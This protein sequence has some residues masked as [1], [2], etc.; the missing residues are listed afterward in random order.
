MPKTRPYLFYDVALS[1]CSTCY[2]RKVEAKTV[3]QDGSVYLL[4]RCP[5]HGPE[6][7]LIADDIDYYPAAAAKSSSS[8]PRCPRS[9]QHPSQMGMP[10]TAASAPTNEQHSCLN[11]RSRSATTA[12]AALPSS[13]YG[14]QR[15]RERQ[16]SAPSANRKMLDA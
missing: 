9:Y 6:R 10:T 4:K 7:V 16:Q 8:P 5:Q 12:N 1:I 11:P 3:F 15:A 13:C 2:P 14:R